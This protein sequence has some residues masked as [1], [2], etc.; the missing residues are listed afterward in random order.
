MVVLFILFATR[1]VVVYYLFAAGLVWVLGGCRWFVCC[2]L[3]V[4]LVLVWV[5]T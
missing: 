5:L 1:F 4:G 2:L 3:V